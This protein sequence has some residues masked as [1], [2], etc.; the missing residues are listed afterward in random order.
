MFKI[1][2]NFPAEAFTLGMMGLGILSWTAQADYFRLGIPSLY[3]HI[4]AYALLGFT[5]MAAKGTKNL[6]LGEL[7]LIILIAACLEAFKA[8]LPFRHPKLSDFYADLL[9]LSLSVTFSTLIGMIA[10]VVWFSG[11][12]LIQ[13]FH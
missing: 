2:R 5:L 6:S 4:I 12:R 7:V 9:G 11:N 1:L 8:E 13:G 10:R 3:E